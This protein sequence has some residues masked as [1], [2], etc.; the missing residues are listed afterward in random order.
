MPGF[1]QIEELNQEQLNELLWQ[2]LRL[3]E[4]LVPPL[5]RRF[6]M[7]APEELFIDALAQAERPITF[8][9]RL[10]RAIGENLQ[11]SIRLTAGTNFDP[12]ANE[13]IASLAFLANEIEANELAQD[14]YRAAIFTGA[15]EGVAE[16]TRFHLLRTLAGLQANKQL[17][18]YWKQLWA[19]GEST[20]RAIAIYGLSQIDPEGILEL[21]P[22]ILADDQLDLPPIIWHLATERPGTNALGR[23]AR[24]LSEANRNQLRDSLAIAGADDSLLRTFDLQAARTQ[25]G[26]RFSVPPPKDRLAARHRPHWQTNDLPMVA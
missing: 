12:T 9:T 4:P 18:P 15:A 16:Q 26:F 23:K 3:E 7:E 13:Q 11:R 21:L 17:I 8:K 10:Q 22:E 14:F 20:I 5:D 1:Q 19:S 24:Q 25:P 6:R 2:R